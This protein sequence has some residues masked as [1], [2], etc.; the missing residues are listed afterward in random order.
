MKTPAR[1]SASRRRFLAGVAG[2]AAGLVIPL[3]LSFA[4]QPSG[5]LAAALA[6][7]TPWIRIG[8]D[9]SVVLYMSQAEMGQ[10]IRTGL[11]QVLAE[12]L[13]ADWNRIRLENAPVAA[14]YQITI[15]GFS[16]QFTAASSS[17]T[18]LYEPLRN[19]GAG[20]R[21]MLTE[22]AARDWQ[23]PAAE[24][25][26]RNGFISHKAS[27]RKLS[28]GKLAAAASTLPIPGNPKL[29][30]R[31][32][33]RYIGKPLRRLDTPSKTNGSA[34]F[35]IDVRVPD[36]L[37]AAI[38]HCP[39]FGGKITGYNEQLVKSMPGVR[40]V[41]PTQDALIVVAEN[42]W[43]ARA[44][45]Q[46][47]EL[48]VDP[49]PAGGMSSDTLWAA[50]RGGLDTGAPLVARADGDVARALSGAVRTIEAEYMVPYLAHAAIEPV[51]C[52]ADVRSDGCTIWAP[53]QGPARV[54]ATLANMLKLP[55]E[56]IKVNVTYLGGGFGRKGQPDFVIEAALA[57]R[58]VGRPVKL[59]WSREEDMRQD[60]YRPGFVGRYRAG[61]DASGNL[62]AMSA[63]IAAQS[64]LA[65]LNPRWLRKDRLDET[66]VEGTADLPY[67]IPNFLVEGV[68]VE[69][70]VRLGWLR[71]IGHGPNAFMVESFIDEVAHAAGSD[72]YQFRRVLLKN[73]KRALAVLDAAAKAARWGRKMPPGRALGI[74]YHTYT[75]RAEIYHTRSAQVAEVSVAADGKLRVHSIYAAVDCGTVVN[76]RLVEA[77]VQGSIGWGLSAA[78]KGKITF[79]GGQVQ[80]SNFHDY[81]LLTLAEMPKI[82]VQLI[83]GGGPPAGM[84]EGT[85]P[86][87]APAV[88]NAIFAATG[89]RLRSSPLLDL[90]LKST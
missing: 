13:E 9:E 90:D 1:Y 39:V 62:V 8:A 42:Y 86:P 7:V 65:Q 54:K 20:A 51:N 16:G 74:A 43:Q 49:G 34:M 85:V 82:D 35:G 81:P 66:T 71:S 31:G 78:L 56:A 37:H 89:K 28:Y 40:A 19:A 18:L 47:L 84:G 46:A 41:V 30:S 45:A 6:Q 88:A 87:T 61:L 2:G 24:C 69:G 21:E 60:Y 70:P 27:G 67:A 4:Q 10:G 80:Q 64:L 77:Q 33:F 15:R 11:A 68:N 14:P 36:M 12:E 48:N 76:P 22:A 72:P 23:V 17:M 32:E 73:D 75:G 26:A 52:T 38:R 58:A 63:R 50:L 55:P 59:V 3:R 29:K 57:S 5:T 53:T 83:D 79:A 44:A 25:V